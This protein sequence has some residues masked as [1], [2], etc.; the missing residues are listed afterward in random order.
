MI[1]ASDLRDALNYDPESGE[2]TWARPKSNRMKPGDRAGAP[3]N[4]G[5]VLVT[6][7]WK[8]YRA[9]KL[10]WLYVTGVWPTFEIDHIDGNRGNNRWSNLRRSDRTLNTLNQRDARSH[11]SKS[12]VRGVVIKSD[13][14]EARITVYGEARNLGKFETAD[15]ASAAYESARL[16]VL[17]AA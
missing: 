16:A 12:G 11:K 8:K 3:N 1:T 13:G 2:F 9:H 5:Y 6:L 14:Y 17:Q 10:A 7:G 4:L 15:E